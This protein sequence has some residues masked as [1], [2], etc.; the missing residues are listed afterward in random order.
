MYYKD[1]SHK[2][3]IVE[4]AVDCALILAPTITDEHR[5]NPLLLT[6]DSPQ[7]TK[8]ALLYATKQFRR[9]VVVASSA[10]SPLHLDRGSNFL[11]TSTEVDWME[12][13]ASAYYNIF[14][15][16]YLLSQGSCVI[17]NSVGGY[18]RWASRIANHS[19][20]IDLKEQAQCDPTLSLSI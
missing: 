18:G 7:V 5:S 4:R 9:R 3:S 8:T 19:C 15:D 17:Y 11:G 20:A 10:N 1:K 12:Y 6:S 16:L 14:V 13:P 2:K